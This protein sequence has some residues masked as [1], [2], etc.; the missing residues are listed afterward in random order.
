MKPTHD[1]YGRASAHLE[2]T[3]AP[4]MAALDLS[5]HAAVSRATS[6]WCP[7][8]DSRQGAETPSHSVMWA[9]I[10]R[11]EMLARTA[12]PRH[13]RVSRARHGCTRD[14]TRQCAARA[15]V[16]PPGRRR[17]RTRDGDTVRIGLCS[18]P[19]GEGLVFVLLQEERLE[20]ENE[21]LRRV[22]VSDKT[23]SGYEKCG[24]RLKLGRLGRLSMH[25][26]LVQLTV[27]ED[28]EPERGGLVELG[29]CGPVHLACGRA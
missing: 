24:P 29:D 27:G 11:H 22:K 14:A 1:A 15:A 17:V 6:A 23:T 16:G 25:E 28:G 21:G 20:L 8:R 4:W 13:A 3:S 26:G 9:L 19:R 7:A 12:L 2:S 5:P 18:D 10:A